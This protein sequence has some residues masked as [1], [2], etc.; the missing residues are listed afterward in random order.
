MSAET[1]G[2]YISD[3]TMP[4]RILYSC[5]QISVSYTHLD[6]QTSTF[7]FS[8]CED[9]GIGALEQNRTKMARSIISRDIG[10]KKNRRRFSF[11]FSL[12]FTDRYEK[13]Y[14][15]QHYKSSSLLRPAALRGVLQRQKSK[16]GRKRNS[17]QSLPL[18]YAEI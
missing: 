16:Q 7:S 2:N 15:K 6:K 8:I 3:L 14:L 17:Y 12:V 18:C 11:N 4:N 10:L 13:E 9:N 1:R 5:L